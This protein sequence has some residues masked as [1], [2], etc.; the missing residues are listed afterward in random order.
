MSV[1]SEDSFDFDKF[2]LSSEDNEKYNEENIFEELNIDNGFNMFAMFD[3]NDASDKNEIMN[4]DSP[5]NKKNKKSMV[6]VFLD[7]LDKSNQ[8]LDITNSKCTT[9]I[10]KSG[11]PKHIIDSRANVPCSNCKN[12]IDLKISY[13]FVQ[14]SNKHYFLCFLCKN[15]FIMGLNSLIIDKFKVMELNN[16]YSICTK[17]TEQY[18]I[19]KEKIINHKC[20]LNNFSCFLEKYAP[21]SDVDNIITKIFDKSYDN[22]K[23][24]K[25]YP[26][27]KIYNFDMQDYRFTN[28]SRIKSLLKNGF[29]EKV[30]DINYKFTKEEYGTYYEYKAEATNKC[31]NCKTDLNLNKFKLEVTKYNKQF[32]NEIYKYENI[33]YLLYAVC[34]SCIK[35]CDNVQKKC[36]KYFVELYNLKNFNEVVSKEIKN[37]NT[38]KFLKN[39]NDVFME[40]LEKNKIIN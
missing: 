9:N 32:K 16:T 11:I 14:T 22:I 27:I 4:I 31:V 37:K 30:D 12:N 28:Q 29:I 2:S 38:S 34:N 17:D 15:K 19:I 36:I 33:F 20:S 10:S 25:P 35:Y 39:Y 3:A 8:T 23:H 6:D 5:S 40:L 18:Q 24:C 1:S 26:N 13:S 21:K 7:M